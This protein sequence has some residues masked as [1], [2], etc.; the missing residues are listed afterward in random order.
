VG[1]V[2]L[3]S[4]AERVIDNCGKCEQFLNEAVLS[5]DMRNGNIE[6]KRNR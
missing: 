3:V 4:P 6:A 1:A 5:A 2:T